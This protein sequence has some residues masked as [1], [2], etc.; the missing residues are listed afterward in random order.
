MNENGTLSINE[1]C[2]MLGTTSRTLRFYEE[3][4][5]ISSTALPFQKQRHYTAEQIEHIKK[6]LVLRSLGLSVAKIG[7]LQRGDSNLSAV[8]AEHRAELIASIVSKTKEINLLDE[9]LSAIESGGDIFANTEKSEEELM[10]EQ[11]KIA[12]ICTNAVISGDFKRCFSYFSDKM[13][14]YMPLTAFECAAND[15]LKPLGKF[16]GKEKTVFDK[17]HRNVMFSYLKYEKLGLYIKY[18]FHT[19]KLVGI[20][21]NYYEIKRGEGIV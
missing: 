6:V 3:K 1:V 4:G 10:S 16:V 11:A 18:V 7:E 17:L 2:T 13:K 12:D 15:T 8:I 20:W 19:D 5:I 21:L 14:E 9:A